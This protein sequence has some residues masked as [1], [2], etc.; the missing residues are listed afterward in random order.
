KLAVLLSTFDR[1][2]DTVALLLRH[3]AA[4]PAVSAVYLLWL[5]PATS[6]L[7]EALPPNWPHK[8]PP[9][10]GTAPVRIL[11]APRDSL[12]ARFLPIPSLPSSSV[13]VADDDVL[14]S[15]AALDLLRRAHLL[16]PDRPAGF[17][18]R[19]HARGRDGYPRYLAGAHEMKGYSLALTKLMAAPADLLFLYS[20]ALPD[21]VHALVDR[22]ANCEDLAAGFVAAGTAGKAPL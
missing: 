17:H 10:P 22:E 15:H 21:A 18:A 3:Y 6:S 11:P 1:D 19:G 7:A 2:L 16:D 9:P 20:C 13:L 5:N 12:N 8:A 14:P 4:S